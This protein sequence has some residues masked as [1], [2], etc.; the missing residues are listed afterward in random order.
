[1]LSCSLL[2]TPSLK[3]KVNKRGCLDMV[4]PNTTLKRYA[5]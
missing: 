5:K 3:S 1:M 2:F 4:N